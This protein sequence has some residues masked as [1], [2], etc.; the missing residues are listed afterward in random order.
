MVVNQELLFDLDQKVFV[1]GVAS[2][3][4]G[5]AHNL[6]IKFVKNGVAGY[7]LPFGSA[8]ELRY[9]DHF[10]VSASDP[11]HVIPNSSFVWNATLEVYE[12][13]FNA[14]QRPLN[15]ISVS[16]FATELIV[17]TAENVTFKFH[18]KFRNTQLPAGIDP[19]DNF[20]DQIP[21]KILNFFRNN[22]RYALLPDKPEFNDLN[23]PDLIDVIELFDVQERFDNFGITTVEAAIPQN[24]FS[25]DVAPPANV[26]PG[27][28]A[29]VSVLR[30]SGTEEV[31]PNGSHEV[32]NGSTRVYLKT[33]PSSGVSHK[34]VV[35]YGKR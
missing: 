7:E 31:L 14:E 2:Q 35:S 24:A 34:L 9:D 4:I 11:I 20:D 6:R 26:D 16:T 32:V 12:A 29:S 23:K 22:F 13:G 17:S 33:S 5:Y 8:L 25:V 15:L 19:C 1:N 10:P 18:T 3:P 21:K 28:I 30:L 27:L